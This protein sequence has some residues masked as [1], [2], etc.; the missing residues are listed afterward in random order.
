VKHKL[1][2]SQWPSNTTLQNIHTI[3]VLKKNWEGRAN[4]YH[5]QKQNIWPNA[6]KWLP[7]DDTTSGLHDML[8]GAGGS[9]RRKS[10][11]EWDKHDFSDRRPGHHNTSRN[12]RVPNDKF[13]NYGISHNTTNIS[14]LLL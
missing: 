14:N 10:R 8:P 2:D 11:S 13:C 1:K 4:W 6:K 5:Y 7:I 3:Y 12:M 9:V